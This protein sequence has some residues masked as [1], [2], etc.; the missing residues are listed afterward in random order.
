ME[1]SG[2]F[3][4]QLLNAFLLRYLIK[5]ERMVT[6]EAARKARE[7]KVECK[8]CHKTIQKGSMWN[9]LKRHE[10]KKKP[11]NNN[12]TMCSKSFF[13][14]D[15]L[16]QHIKCHTKPLVCHICESRFAF[17]RLLKKHLI[18]EHQINSTL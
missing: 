8:V 4:Y 1:F 13:T 2:E 18:S 3:C 12:C 17:K 14:I 6:K 16:K 15:E 10:L 5:S 7:E 9:H 11:K